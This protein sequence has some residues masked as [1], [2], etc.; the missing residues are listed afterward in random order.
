[1]SP[2]DKSVFSFTIPADN[3][4]FIHMHTQISPVASHL[5]PVSSNLRPYSKRQGCQ[6]LTEAWPT[7]RYAYYASQLPI[8]INRLSGLCR[9]FCSKLLKVNTLYITISNGLISCD[10]CH[11][12]LCNIH[13]HTKDTKYRLVQPQTLSRGFTA[14]LTLHWP[15][16]THFKKPIT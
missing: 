16:R 2:T 8:L 11:S 13:Q 6:I 3:Q 10:A 7:N 15:L 14:H 5:V 1:M 4:M 12:M 9:L